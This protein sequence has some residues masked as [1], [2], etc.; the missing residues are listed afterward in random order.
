MKC[1]SF[2]GGDKPEPTTVTVSAQSLTSK[3][4]DREVGQSGS[5]LNS[6]NV[7]GASSESMGRPLFPIISPGQS[8]LRV[9]TVSELKS[10]TKNFNRGFMLGEGGFGCVYKGSIKNREDSSRK[11]DVAVKKLGKRGMQGHKEWVTEVN[12]LGVA[13]HPNL[14]KLIGYSAEDDER[15]MQ[16]LLI[17]EFMP[18]RSVEFHL[19]TRSETTLSWAMRLKIAQDAARGLTYLHEEMDFQIIFRDFKSS[20]I[21]IDEQWN[22]KLS[23]FGLAR[24]GP[25]D[26]LTHVSTAVVGTWGY[27]AP[28][29]IQTGRLTS[30][31]DVWS[32]G[33]FLYELITGR[34]PLD[35]NRPKGEQK[36][37][38]WV[39]P[40]LSDVKKFRQILDPRLQGNYHLK[41][42]K[43]LATVANRCLVRNP[44]SRPKMSEVL[45]IVNKIVDA[46]TETESLELSVNSLASMETS[47]NSTAD[48]KTRDLDLKTVESGWFAW[49]WMPKLIGTC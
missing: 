26:G 22:A 35:R 49:M 3:H 23:D 20:N 40:Y 11:I 18:N 15:G 27:A 33:V 48:S 2:Y 39:R 44:K 24:L 37:L 8:N 31:I 36:L 19:S 16:R 1:F 12:L 29:Y 34:R 17:Y 21:L 38:E 7:S 10:A 5:E 28:E 43:K 47:K 14:V 46:S 41:S 45:D 42:A 9:F 6:Q 4:S 32:Y 25:Q 30:K 13:Q